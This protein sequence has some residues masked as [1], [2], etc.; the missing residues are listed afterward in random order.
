MALSA[1]QTH[2][3]AGSEQITRLA[4]EIR[5]VLDYLTAQGIGIEAQFGAAE[6]DFS[7]RLLQ[8]DEGNNRIVVA[9]SPLEEGNLAVLGRQR[10][11]FIATPASS[12]LEFVATRPR[13]TLHEG[14]PA[15]EF[16]FPEVLVYLKRRRSPRVELEPDRVWAHV[17][18][19]AGGV[20]AFDA[21]L[22][23]ISDTGVAL[24]YAAEIILEPGTLLKGCRIDLPRGDSLSFDVEVRYSQPVTVA[25]GAQARRSGCRFIGAPPDRPLIERLM[26]ADSKFM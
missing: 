24:V 23:D 3:P 13:Q 15:I 7:S 9:C 16:D 4:S 14:A 1:D 17:V 10:C 8:V 25:D 26:L 19:D 22:A 2:A 6:R 20:L 5:R 18:A 21:Y 12:H 11:T